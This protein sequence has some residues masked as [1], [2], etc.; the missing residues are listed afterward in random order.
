METACQPCRGLRR[1]RWRWKRTEKAAP[2]MRVRVIMSNRRRASGGQRLDTQRRRPSWL[3]VRLRPVV[4]PWLASRAVM[5]DVRSVPSVPG[6]AA[7]ARCS[8]ASPREPRREE[9]EA[10]RV[11]TECEGVARA[12]GATAKGRTRAAV[13]DQRPAARGQSNAAVE[14]WAAGPPGGGE[15]V[16]D[17]AG[18]AAGQAGKAHGGTGCGMPGRAPAAARASSSR[19]SAPCRRRGTAQ[20]HHRHDA[21]RAAPGRCG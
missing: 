11:S 16:D 1:P 3:R 15:V 12:R 17:N 21:A 2:S 9:E 8:S 14:A 13:D 10:S 20:A 6:E 5:R 7:R 4:R 18:A 19:P